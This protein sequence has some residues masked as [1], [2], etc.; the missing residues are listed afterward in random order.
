MK[1][2]IFINLRRR[3][4]K[5]GASN[6][7][8]ILAVCFFIALSIAATLYALEVNNHIDHVWQ[9]HLEWLRQQES[10]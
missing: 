10:R 1:N 3:H 6:R 8:G 7:I 4:N 9:E 5:K 2:L